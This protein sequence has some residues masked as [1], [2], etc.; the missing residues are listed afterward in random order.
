M[1]KPDDVGGLA[2]ALGRLQEHSDLT[3][4]PGEDSGAKPAAKDLG[5]SDEELI[6]S[7]RDALR[8][9]EGQ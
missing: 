5:P 8:R 1:Q 7:L 3:G 4:A 2:E 6:R 9:V